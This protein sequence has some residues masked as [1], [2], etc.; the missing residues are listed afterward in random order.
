MRLKT[1]PQDFIVEE[2]IA[3]PQGEGPYTLYRVRKTG[4]TTLEVQAALAQ[5]LGLPRRAVAFPG[6]KDKQ[7]VAVQWASAKGEGPERLQGRGWE[8]LR[9]GRAARPLAPHDLLGNAFTLTVRDVEAEEVSP[10]R[11]ALEGRAQ[12]GLPN[13][14]DRQRFGSY[15]PGEGF[16]GKALL[17]EEWEKAL[18]LFLATPF[19][20]DGPQVRSFKAE[21][22]RRWGAWAD[23]LP[24]A[25]RGPL[26]SV[27]TYLKDH[28]T[29]FRRAADRIAPALLSLFLAAY[30]AWLWNAIAGCWLERVLG[31]HIVPGAR[32]AIA[33]QALPLYDVLPEA[34]QKRLHSASLPLPHAKMSFPDT[35]AQACVQEVLAQ[36]GLTLRDLKARR[37]T[38]AYLAKGERPLL[39][40]PQGLSVGEACPDER[41]PGRWAITVSFVLPPGSYATLVVKVA[42]I[43]AGLPPPKGA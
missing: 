41:F 28:P 39:L 12:Y 43:L 21:A 6:M 25:P 22:R 20:G 19:L 2:R 24:L 10:L 13:Y 3:L 26:R 18:S 23:L 7:A 30:Q 1:L 36:E 32:L 33:R 35:M 15:A 29:E 4:V 14:F 9:W 42:S 16:M 37:L 27:L 11:H 8:A 40:F 34:L 5:R 17:L 31:P 38:H